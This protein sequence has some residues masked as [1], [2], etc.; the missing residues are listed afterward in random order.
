M[1]FINNEIYTRKYLLYEDKILEWETSTEKQ[2][3]QLPIMLEFDFKENWT[4]MLAVNRMWNYWRIKEET[5]AYFT[6]REETENERFTRNTNF[7]ERWTEPDRIISEDDMAFLSGLSIKIS[8]KFQINI[9]ASPEFEPHWRVSQ[10]WL[11]FKA[12][13]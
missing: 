2:T 6:V 5:V 4:L 8:P 3:L 7:G 12:G 11:G 10:W 1:R 13:L 9:M